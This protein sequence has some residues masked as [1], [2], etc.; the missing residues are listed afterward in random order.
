MYTRQGI[1]SHL[2]KKVLDEPEFLIH[3]EHNIYNE[4]TTHNMNPDYLNPV[5][6]GEILDTTV[7]LYK[8]QFF[9]LVLLHGPFTGFYLV[10][11]FIILFLFEGESMF[12]YIGHPFP[13]AI[14]Y[15]LDQLWYLDRWI[16]YIMCGCEILFIY[17]IT[18]SAQC[19][20]LSD[21][22][23]GNRI[24]LKNAYS[25]ACQVWVPAAIN[26]SILSVLLGILIISGLFGAVFLT[27][28]SGIE[29][30]YP[31]EIIVMLLMSCLFSL[32]VIFIWTKFSLLYPVM[33]NEQGVL[34]AFKRS[35]NLVKG[36]TIKVFFSLFLFFILFPGTLISTIFLEGLY[37]DFVNLVFI[38]SALLAQA[39]LVPLLD[40]TRTVLYFRLRAFKEGLDIQQRIQR[41][42][43]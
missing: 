7:N 22:I 37:S 25:R 18:A 33:I 19:S 21:F 14:L 6:F 26:N 10:Y 43:R 40:T 12:G 9:H 38:I 31:W 34:K 4:K 1:P 11:V 41:L 36:H 35:W 16:M 5:S 23:E 39:L 17:P 3:H 28:L 27:S 8:K 42:E 13:D 32:P 24:S 30:F 15:S 29:M 20:F 2:I